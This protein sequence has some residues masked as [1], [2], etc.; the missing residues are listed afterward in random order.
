[1]QNSSTYVTAPS[2]LHFGF[3]AFGNREGPQFGGCG[4]M[5]SRPRTTIR[6]TGHGPFRIAADSTGRAAEFARTWSTH[7]QVPLA[8]E[9]EV[10]DR[11]PSHVGLGSG[12]QM[13]LAIATLLNRHVG[14]P[15]ADAEELAQSM[16]RGARSALGTYGFLQ[17]GFV[18]ELGKQ[19]N[20]TLG[21]QLCRVA[22]PQD[23]RVLLVSAADQKGLC[24]IA[25][26][27]AFASDLPPVP[28]ST[29][30][31]MTDILID[32]MIPALRH[33]ECERFGQAIY[34]YGLLAGSC[35]EK[36][37]GGPFAS[38]EAEQVVNMLRNYGVAGVGQS[39]W[40]P[41]LFGIVESD[42]VAQQAR[43]RLA[44]EANKEWSADVVEFD[45]QGVVLT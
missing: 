5:V 33:G 31:A 32:R 43:H 24:G 38:A 1:M 13:A 12:T 25:E 10:I 6:I 27:R 21:K 44:G 2:R 40:G 7:A 41:T 35:F 26:E 18:A 19:E 9:L 34:E 20:E 23:W 3:L 42:E 11:T 8:G 4:V 30:V 22:M 28:R 14:R 36:L 16:D 29:T 17:G 39:S 37:Q 45:N 15:P